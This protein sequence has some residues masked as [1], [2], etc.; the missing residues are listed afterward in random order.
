MTEELTD[1]EI[2]IARQLQILADKAGILAIVMNTL[3]VERI[4][5]GSTNFNGINILRTMD[6]PRFSMGV[7]HAG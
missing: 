6:S 7:L 3:D 4:L 1:A 2:T 5:Q